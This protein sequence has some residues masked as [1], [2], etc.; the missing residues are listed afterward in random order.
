MVPLPACAGGSGSPPPAP[1]CPRLWWPPPAAGRGRGL[2]GTSG[3]RSP[4][5]PRSP[6]PLVKVSTL[7]TK[8]LT[9]CC[10]SSSY[11]IVFRELSLTPSVLELEDAVCPGDEEA[12]AGA[13][14]PEHVGSRHAGA[15]LH[16]PPHLLSL[17]SR[18]VMSCQV[19]SGQV[20][21]ARHSP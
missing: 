11:S 7:S 10:E 6:R 20:K 1:A 18:R 14:D 12:G 8:F 21:S 2:S 17:H 19:M 15:A 16:P 3:A 5:G 13:R 4:A 9:R